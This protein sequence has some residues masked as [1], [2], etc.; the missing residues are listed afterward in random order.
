MVYGTI[1]HRSDPGPTID[2]VIPIAGY[3]SEPV[4]GR[5]MAALATPVVKQFWETVFWEQIFS[6]RAGS[7]GNPVFETDTHEKQSYPGEVFELYHG[8]EMSVLCR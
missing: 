3:D 7:F 4:L 2:D 8:L 5:S 1:R 6:D